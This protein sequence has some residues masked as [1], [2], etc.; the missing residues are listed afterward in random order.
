MVSQPPTRHTYLA[1]YGQG[2]DSWWNH[3]QC[4]YHAEKARVKAEVESLAIREV[5][6][7]PAYPLDIWALIL[8]VKEV[9]N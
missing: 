3:I 1:M 8:W 7:W 5:L 4:G 6:G 2:L 9:R